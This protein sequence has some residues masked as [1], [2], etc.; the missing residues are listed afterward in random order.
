MASNGA[1]N[2][3][4]RGVRVPAAAGPTNW[5]DARARKLQAL[6]GA[7]PQDR[8]LPLRRDRGNQGSDSRLTREKAEVYRAEDRGPRPRAQLEHVSVGV[9]RGT[10]LP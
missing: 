5:H 2:G 9:L 8:L 3:N 10:G 6:Q 7:R 4:G 1:A